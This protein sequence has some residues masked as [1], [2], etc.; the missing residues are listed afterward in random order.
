[1]QYAY[2]LFF[3]LKDI[4][5]FWHCPYV[6]LSNTAYY[7]KVFYDEN[8]LPKIICIYRIV[9]SCF[10]LL[11]IIWIYWIVNFHKKLPVRNSSIP[12]IIESGNAMTGDAV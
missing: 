1:M 4:L 12:I 7:F 6:I 9:Y 3:Q 10:F 11:L 2:S 5:L 8:N